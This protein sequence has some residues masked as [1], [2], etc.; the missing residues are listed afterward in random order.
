[1]KRLLN[2]EDYGDIKPFVIFDLD[3]TLLDTSDLYWK[4]REEFIS[5]MERDGFGD[6]DLAACFESID[7]VNI[8]KYGHSPERYKCTMLEMY[9]GVA[10]FLTDKKTKEIIRIAK[11]ISVEVPQLIDGALELL[12][13]SKRH[14]RLALVTRGEPNV[15][16]AKIDKHGLVKYFEENIEIVPRKDENLFAELIASAGYLPSQTIIIGDSLK[17]EVNPA[18]RIGATAI[19]YMYSHHSYVWLQEHTEEPLNRNYFQ[20]SRLS[21]AKPILSKFM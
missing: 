16:M 1:M 21:Q 3:D 17:S 2:K 7:S 5:L 6:K 11:Q 13:W 19:H 8:S 20:I 12:E 14:F 10:G 18:L 4:V 9:R 15:Q